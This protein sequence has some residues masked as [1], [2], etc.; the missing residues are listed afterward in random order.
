MIDDDVVLSLDPLCFLLLLCYFPLGGQLLLLLLESS[1]K[2]G[3]QFL[4]PLS[5]LLLVFLSLGLLLV[6]DVLPGDLLHD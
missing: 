1:L 3:P 2:L 5:L 6:V 4:V